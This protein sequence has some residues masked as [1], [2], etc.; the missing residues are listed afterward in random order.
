MGGLLGAGLYHCIPIGLFVILRWLIGHWA[1]Y[2]LY[3]Y[4]VGYA[5]HYFLLQRVSKRVP[6]ALLRTDEKANRLEPNNKIGLLNMGRLSVFLHKNDTFL[7]GGFLCAL[8]EFQFILLF[9]SPNHLG[10]PNA[11]GGVVECLLI[12]IDNVL[13]EIFLNALQ[14]YGIHLGPELSNLPPLAATV[15]FFFRTASDFAIIMLVYIIFK[16]SRIRG[17]MLQMPDE[18]DIDQC[19]AWFDTIIRGNEDWI[20]SCMDEVVFLMLARHY[21]CGNYEMVQA[22]SRE[23]SMIRVTPDVRNLFVHPR[24][25][26]VL[27]EG[28][29]GAE[30]KK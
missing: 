6:V 23:F 15:L 17:L 9:F 18:D 1:E 12:G 22:L 10:I 26:E 20:R 14:L 11:S 4:L 3:A 2:L 29:F 30:S 25:G 13:H 28:T 5:Y 19:L 16:R 24:T 8:L 7:F 27:F 21:I